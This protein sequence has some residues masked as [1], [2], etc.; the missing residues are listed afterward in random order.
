M[1]NVLCLCVCKCV[2]LLIYLHNENIQDSSV[3]PNDD[4]HTSLKV[5]VVFQCIW[6]AFSIALEF[7][8]ERC[9]FL[10]FGI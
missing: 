6:L 3:L 2:E 5:W 7:K 1:Q 4:Q 10:S 8:K 9:G